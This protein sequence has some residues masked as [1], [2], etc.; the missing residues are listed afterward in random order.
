MRKGGERKVNMEG[1]GKG[2]WQ[3][4]GGSTHRPEPVLR[5]CEVHEALLKYL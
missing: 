1:G 2:E 5:L 3:G 4:E